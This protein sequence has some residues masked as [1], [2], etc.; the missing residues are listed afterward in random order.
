MDTDKNFFIQLV[1]G[2]YKVTKMFPEKEPLKI[3]IRK[4]ANLV[5]TDL[6]LLSSDSALNEKIL[7]QRVLENIAI[8]CSYFE[9]SDEQNWIDKRNFLVLKANYDKIR[10][11]VRKR[12]FVEIDSTR[13]IKRENKDNNKNFS[14]KIASIPNS[15][16]IEFNKKISIKRQ[17]K[18]I[19]ILKTNKIISSKELSKKFPG[20]SVRTLRRD[21]GCLIENNIVAKQGN[22]KTT[23]YKLNQIKEAYNQNLV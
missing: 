2:V 3:L 12:V 13:G 6:I 15:K 9:I 19:E 17:E 7:V 10:N 14:K 20:I 4:R 5:L 16:E 8:L 11:K 1:I 18:I 22:S 23:L 21:I